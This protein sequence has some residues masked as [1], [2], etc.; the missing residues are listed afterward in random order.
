MLSLLIEPICWPFCVLGSSRIL[1]RGYGGRL[2]HRRH[3]LLLVGGTH[4][5]YS[6]ISIRHF[7]REV[8]DQAT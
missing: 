2:W 4:R 8:N 3:N 1:R 5:N 7:E 6:Q